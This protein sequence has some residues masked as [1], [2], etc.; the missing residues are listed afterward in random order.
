M[1]TLEAYRRWACGALLPHF[2]D[3]GDTRVRPCRSDCQRVE[4]RCP[5]F[6]P[7]DR[8][9]PW[10]RAPVYPTQYAGEPTFLCLDPHIPETGEQLSKSSYGPASCCFSHCGPPGAPLC[11]RRCEGPRPPDTVQHAPYCAGLANLSELRPEPRPA[12]SACPSTV[13]MPASAPRMRPAWTLLGLLLHF[14]MVAR[15][16]D[17][18]HSLLR[19]TVTFILVRSFTLV[20]GNA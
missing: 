12:L 1:P 20:W 16:G 17:T 14:C 18:D 13:L 3:S 6:L 7:G 8:A 2:V 19:H 10:D 5:F 9:P 11:R 4:Q 15:T